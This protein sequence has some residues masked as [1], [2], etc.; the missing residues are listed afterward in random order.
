MF[1]LSIWACLVGV[2]LALVLGEESNGIRV[3]TLI[4]VLTAT[5]LVPIFAMELPYLIPYVLSPVSAC[6]ITYE[7]VGWL[8]RKVR[9]SIFS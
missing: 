4:A 8:L 7:I 6:F 3:Y 1:F 9:F 5:T 2:L